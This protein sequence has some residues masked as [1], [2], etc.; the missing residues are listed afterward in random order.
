MAHLRLKRC[1]RGVSLIEVLGTLTFGAML[2]AIMVAGVAAMYRPNTTR[3]L[4]QAASALIEAGRSMKASGNFSQVRERA[5]LPTTSY[6][7]SLGVRQ[8]EAVVTFVTD[9]LSTV[10]AVGVAVDVPSRELCVDLVVQGVQ[11]FGRV[12]IGA[13][14]HAGGL[15]DLTVR[16]AQTSNPLLLSDTSV[17]N[18]CSAQAT[19][20]VRFHEA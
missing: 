17:F 20:R 2:M 14:T 18:A 8:G 3:D 16:G 19:P 1:Q 12:E 7:G 15:A 5:G 4:L 13:G 9:R 11:R 6:V 10:G